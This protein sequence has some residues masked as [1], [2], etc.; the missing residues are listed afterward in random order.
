MTVMSAAALSAKEPNPTLSIDI[1]CALWRDAPFDVDALC[2]KAA[3]EAFAFAED[4]SGKTEISLVLADDSFV[5]DLNKTW[6]HVDAPTNV[7]AFPCADDEPA[8]GRERLLGDV[9]VAFQITQREAAAKQ[10][11]L[12]HHLAHLIVHGVLHLLGYD[13]LDDSEAETME[14]LEVEALSR[15]GIG[16]PYAE[17]VSNG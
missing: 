10:I 4:M 16:N 15:L 2:R 13:H 3:T 7:L 1:R 6:R 8:A 12:E 11:P 9:V 17:T 14:A 5:G